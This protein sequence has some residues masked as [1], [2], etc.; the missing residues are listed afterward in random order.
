MERIAIGEPTNFDKEKEKIMK[1]FMAF[2]LAILL[3]ALVISLSGCSTTVPSSERAEVNPHHSNAK[4][5]GAFATGAIVANA[6]A[7]KTG[8]GQALSYV[9]GLVGGIIGA[10]LVKGDE[11]KPGDDEIVYIDPPEYYPQSGYS[12][13]GAISVYCDTTP[14]QGMYPP[15]P[16]MCNDP[17]SGGEAS[18]ESLVRRAEQR[19]GCFNATS[20]NYTQVKHVSYQET[21]HVTH[22]R[23]M[24]EGLGNRHQNDSEVDG[25]ILTVK[26]YR[27]G[28]ALPTDC[29]CQTGNWAIDS[30]RIRK[31][32]GELK[33]LQILCKKDVEN[34][35]CNR[36]PG[37]LS[38]KYYDLADA[39]D[40]KQR[41]GEMR[42]FVIK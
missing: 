11:W 36:N 33:N 9:A 22:Q 21:E 5:I 1:K 23:N 40:A 15:R 39:L 28:G 37:V 2:V 30:M 14:K 18:Y 8:A 38:A 3:Y 35:D 42:K 34:P 10:D 7:R 25:P 32:A 16:G 12:S 26:N 6:I 19:A 17:D 41:Q 20:A 31:R 24:F 29:N 4:K 13:C 27:Y